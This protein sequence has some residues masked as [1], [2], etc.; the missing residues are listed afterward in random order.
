MPCST[1]RQRNRSGGFTLLELLL[2]LV[3]MV[4]VAGLV[5]PSIDR[6]LDGQ[7]VD[8][9]ADLVRAAMGRARVAAIREGKVHA[10]VCQPGSSGMLV[11]P[12]ES[13]AGSSNNLAAVF[14]PEREEARFGSID[15]SDD[16]LPLRVRF[17]STAV[18]DNSRSEA[19]EE[20]AGASASGALQYIL[21][22]PDGTSQDAQVNIVNEQGYQKRIVVRGLTGT[23][24]IA[25]VEVAR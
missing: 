9:G 18:V 2:V 13:L 12:L 22:Y 17:T 20:A 23:A 25:P 19:A 7:K 14:G 11:A 8:K 6:L 10:F 15:F 24:R 21:F 16:Q 5:M 4:V 1:T 3:V